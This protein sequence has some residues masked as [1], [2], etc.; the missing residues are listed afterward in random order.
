V[1]DVNTD[2][3][4]FS[5]Q[6]TPTDG[7]SPELL[8]DF[9]IEDLDAD[10][11]A[12]LAEGAPFYLSVGHLMGGRFG[13]SKVISLRFRRLPRWT[14]EGIDLAKTRGRER[15]KALGFDDAP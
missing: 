1:R 7:T 13:K 9:S 5:A 2:L 3:G 12:L 11:E 15:R 10:D 8:A 14:Q 6:L 4:I